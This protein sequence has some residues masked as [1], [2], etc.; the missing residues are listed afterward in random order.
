MSRNDQIIATT[1]ASIINQA[2]KTRRVNL[3]SLKTGLSTNC[4][5]TKTTKTIVMAM[6]SST[7]TS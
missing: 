5:M 3:Y 4:E 1:I 7:K 2:N 6:N